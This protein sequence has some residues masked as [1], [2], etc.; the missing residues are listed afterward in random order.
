MYIK[1]SFLQPQRPN[2]V[3]IGKKKEHSLS[4]GLTG[5]AED[6]GTAEGGNDKPSKY[7]ERKN[8][9]LMK[10]EAKVRSEIVCLI[11]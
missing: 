6:G 4:H 8:K 1:C 5:E 9:R 10:K 11:G 2:L 3:L 7:Q